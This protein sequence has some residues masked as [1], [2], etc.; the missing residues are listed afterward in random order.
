MPLSVVVV[1]AV[2]GCRECEGRGK[3]LTDELNMQRHKTCAFVTVALLF[4]SFFTN[5]ESDIEY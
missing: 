5:E 4:F 2:D 1:E 3:R